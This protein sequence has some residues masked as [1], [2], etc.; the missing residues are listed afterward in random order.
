[1]PDHG[2]RDGQAAREGLAPRG[3]RR[4]AQ[5]PRT[6]SPR[7]RRCESTPS[8]QIPRRR[9]RGG[10][11]A[12][13]RVHR[14]RRGRRHRVL[15]GP[16]RPDRR[17]PVLRRRREDGRRRVL[18][19]LRRQPRSAATATPPARASRAARR[20]RP[21]TSPR[22]PAAAGSARAPAP[23]RAPAASAAP[24]RPTAGA[25]DGAD[26]RR[27]PP[28]LAIDHRAAGPHLLEDRTAGRLDDAVL[29]RVQRLHAGQRRGLRDGGQRPPV[30]GDARR[31]GR[32]H[33]RE[34][35]VQPD[36]HPRL[37]DPEDQGDLGVRAAD[38]LRPLRL[39]LRPRRLQDARVQ[40]GHADRARRDRRPV[41]LVPGPLRR[42][43]RPVEHG[44]RAAGPALE[45]AQGRDS[46]A[47]ASTSC[48]PARRSPARTS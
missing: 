40:R 39:R 3:R 5:G 11:R 44:P 32:L 30:D 25:V 6:R 14:L 31:G 15:R 17:E 46:P 18:L 2:S 38:D 13:P 36:G 20:S 10:P 34:Q 19:A 33:H 43:R 4:A 27:A 24:P 28:G 45:G 1:M 41:A 16:E 23:R 7:R 9:P 26:R 47:T 48:T 21:P 37:G 8:P 22:T 29:A 42:R 12:R 35:P